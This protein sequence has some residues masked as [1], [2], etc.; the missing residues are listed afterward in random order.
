MLLIIQFLSEVYTTSYL[1]AVII[2]YIKQNYVSLNGTKVFHQIKGLP[3]GCYLSSILCELYLADMDDI[4]FKHL[5]SENDVFVRGVDDYLYLTFDSQKADTFLKLI[6]NGIADYGI[7]FQR[8]KTFTNFRGP[9]TSF[10]FY[11]YKFYPLCWKVEP[12]FSEWVGD[13]TA[14]MYLNPKMTWNDLTK[15]M[16][17]ITH[18]KLH[19]LIIDSNYLHKFAIMKN[20]YLCSKIHAA[21]YKAIHNFLTENGGGTPP[22]S[23]QCLTSIVAAAR[24]ITCK[25]ISIN[26]GINDFSHR[27]V[28]IVVLK[29]F[30]AVLGPTGPFRSLV[31][32]LK[33]T[34]GRMLTTKLSTRFK[35]LLKS[36][37]KNN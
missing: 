27:E 3:Q 11:G 32:L 34:T 31:N 28:K 24:V 30:E 29:A 9:L 7:T 36:L 21:K 10:P 22:S 20:I 15:R 16:K 19:E 14:R 17:M 25:V 37:I 4:Y 23:T 35:K 18:I 2:Q 12:D 33:V 26:N 13:I 1:K 8:S 5:K 6:N